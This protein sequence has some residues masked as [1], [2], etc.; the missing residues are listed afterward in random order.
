MTL[1]L[2]PQ[3]NLPLPLPNDAGNAAPFYTSWN[4]SQM[5]PFLRPTFQPYH[6]RKA[7]LPLTSVQDALNLLAKR[8]APDVPYRDAWEHD[9]AFGQPLPAQATTRVLSPAG[10]M[11]EI[12]QFQP[13]GKRMTL[14][15]VLSVSSRT[16]GELTVLWIRHANGRHERVLLGDL[17]YDNDLT[18]ESGFPGELTHARD[19]YERHVLP[20]VHPEQ[21]ERCLKIYFSY[22]HHSLTDV[23]DH[24][25]TPGVREWYW[26]RTTYHASFYAPNG[27]YAPAK[28]ASFKTTQETTRLQ[29]NGSRMLL[30]EGSMI[31]NITLGRLPEGINHVVLEGLKT[32]TDEL[33]PQRLSEA[34]QR[35]LSILLK[36]CDH[37]QEQV[38]MRLLALTHPELL[39]IPGLMR[40][41]PYLERRAYRQWR[42]K[43]PGAKALLHS[44]CGPLQGQTRQSLSR[45]EQVNLLATL[46]QGGVSTPELA[47]AMLEAAPEGLDGKPGDISDFVRLCGK[48]RAGAA[49]LKAM[50]ERKEG[51]DAFSVFHLAADAGRMWTQVLAQMPDFQPKSVQVQ[52]LHDE[53]ARLHRRLKKTNRPIPS[54]QEKRYAKLDRELNGLTFTRAAMTY[55]LLDCGEALDI[56]VAS[57]DD[58]AY[59]GKCVIVIAQENGETRWC[60]E[61]RENRLVQYK[62]QRNSTPTGSDLQ[63]ALAYAKQTKLSIQTSDLG[64]GYRA[65]PGRAL[66]EFVNEDDLPF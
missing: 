57:Y 42:K 13:R 55:D 15:S 41:I 9:P 19:L 47:Q 51:H 39:S 4:V 22:R 5:R 18:T 50:R 21:R 52:A 62:G 46:H 53:V 36:Q 40:F 58:R 59:D 17:D 1:A 34:Q 37:T 32:L 49:L 65:A 56:C 6:A 23:R 2:L 33:L 24:P 30:M 54:A 63:T 14:W 64:R 29:W 16:E 3:A 11:R 26:L 31:R 12:T 28:C 20:R 8:N 45:R 60:L 25:F 66:P 38:Q 61:V 10:L 27:E 35:D 7:L 48:K 44:L 43:R